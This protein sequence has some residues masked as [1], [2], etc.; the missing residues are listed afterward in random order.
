[1]RPGARGQPTHI[2]TMRL[3]VCNVLL[4]VLM[5]SVLLVGGVGEVTDRWGVRGSLGAAWERV[6]AGALSF[7]QQVP[8]VLANK[9]R[10]GL[11]WL[12][13]TRR[14]IQKARV[15]NVDGRLTLQGSYADCSPEGFSQGTLIRSGDVA[16]QVEEVNLELA[17]RV[18]ELLVKDDWTD[19]TSK[20]AILVQRRTAEDVPTG[21]FP[22][23]VGPSKFGGKAA[24]QV[25]CVKASG[26]INAPISRVYKLFLSND[27]VLK[28]NQYCSEIRDVG[29]LDPST[30]ISWATSK[31]MGPFSA[32][33]FVTRCH[34]RCLRDGSLLLST[35]SEAGLPCTDFRDEGSSPGEYVRMDVI[36]G[37]Y[38]FQSIGDGSKTRFQMVSLCNPGGALDSTVGAMISSMLCASGPIKFISALRRLSAANA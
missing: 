10:Q 21:G 8:G 26:E 4:L 24:S 37:G 18:L 11:Q 28:Y 22:Q 14:R 7:Q 6:E 25:V 5:Q 38:L 2:C 15:R 31:K 34:Y 29:F 3:S 12:E 35:M 9:H 30:K 20:E 27:Y 17:R 19:V 1:V 13:N 16:N 33:D 23:G 32:R 36:L